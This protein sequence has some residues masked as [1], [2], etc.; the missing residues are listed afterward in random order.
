MV[1]HNGAT[2]KFRG[3]NMKFVSD[4]KKMFSKVDCLRFGRYLAN[5]NKS[6][7]QSVDRV[8][9]NWFNGPGTREITLWKHGTVRRIRLPKR[10]EEVL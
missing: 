9:D 6:M 3:V 2:K 8:F 7:E 1:Y 5:G 10:R 4:I